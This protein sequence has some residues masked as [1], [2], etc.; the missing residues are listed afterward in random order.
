MKSSP[1]ASRKSDLLHPSN[2]R[3]TTAQQRYIPPSMNQG[4]FDRS[5][6]I[7]SQLEEVLQPTVADFRLEEQLARIL[8]RVPSFLRLP[9]QG[10]RCPHTQLCRT[11]MLDLVA[12]SAR[13]GNCPPVRAIYRR[14]HKYAQRG[15]WLIPAEN[16]FR[17]L[18]SLMDSPVEESRVPR[19]RHCGMGKATPPV[20]RD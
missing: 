12:P 13:N 10:S 17:H 5:L 7:I 8:T 3:T 18:L 20:G 19:D 1:P 2:T 6:P 11:A 16:L 14:A 15:V 9:A 4:Q